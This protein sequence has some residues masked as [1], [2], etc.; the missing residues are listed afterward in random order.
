MTL[1]TPKTEMK[2]NLQNIY[3]KNQNNKNPYFFN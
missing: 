1:R 2:L 3:M